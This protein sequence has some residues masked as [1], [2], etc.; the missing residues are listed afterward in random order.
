[1][2]MTGRLCV[3]V[4]AEAQICPVV[5][6]A[7]TI[8]DTLPSRQESVNNKSNKNDKIRLFTATDIPLVVVLVKF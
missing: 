4:C 6:F 2:I 1:M 5:G 3:C 7:Y 8:F